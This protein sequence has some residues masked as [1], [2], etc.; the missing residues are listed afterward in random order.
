MVEHQYLLHFILLVLVP[1]SSS[2]ANLISQLQLPT[3][4]YIL[5]KHFGLLNDKFEKYVV[6]PKCSSLYQFKE[7][8]SSTI[9]GIAPK[10]CQ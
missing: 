4:L 2:M 8:F 9:T 7:W 3:S 6:C 5:K 1:K 10:R